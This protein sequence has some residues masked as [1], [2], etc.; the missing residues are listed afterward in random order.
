MLCWFLASWGSLSVANFLSFLEC[1]FLVVFEKTPVVADLRWGSRLPTRFC[2]LALVPTA[3]DPPLHLWFLASLG[4]S[5]A[6]FLRLF[7]CLLV[8][9]CRYPSFSW[10]STS[11]GSLAA[12]LLPQ[13]LGCWHS[14]RFLLSARRV[15]VSPFLWCR[16]LVL[17]CRSA[18]LSRL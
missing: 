18:G 11:W 1:A 12:T 7:R 9:R 4:T 10:S 5:M 2:F 6:F 14:V 15:F 17:W 13:L 8:P 3:W 16:L